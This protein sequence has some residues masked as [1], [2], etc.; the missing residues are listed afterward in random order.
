MTTCSPAAN[1]PSWPRC[2]RRTPSSSGRTR[3]CGRHRLFRGTARPDPV[4]ATALFD[5]HPHLEVE[6]TLRE[7]HIPS[8]SYYRWRQAETEPCER[9][10]QDAAL[11]NRIRQVYDESG[12]IYGSPR[13]HAVLKREGVHVG[14]KRVERLMRQAGLAGIGVLDRVPGHHQHH[15]V[16][17]VAPPPVLLLA[18]PGGHRQPDLP[19]L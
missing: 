1:A 8:P 12:G 7:L 16:P 11:T 18:E 6:P 3:S 17:L 4:Q 5:E 10:R 2:A 19:E 9:H 14:R 15:G 13:V